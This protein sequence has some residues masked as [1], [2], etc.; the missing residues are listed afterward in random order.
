MALDL[1][2]RRIGVAVSD[3]AGIMAHPLTTL[4]T[5]KQ[6]GFPL[7]ALRRL[8]VDRQVGGVVVGLPRRLDGSR[9]P[10]AQAAEEVA[11]ELHAALE[12]PVR[13]WDE[14]LTTVEAQRLLREAGAGRKKRRLATDRVAAALILQGFL[15]HEGDTAAGEGE[16][17]GGQGSKNAQEP[18]EAR[19]T[20]SAP[21]R[22][23]SAQQGTTKGTRGA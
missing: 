11:A 4:E 13:L 2:A 9:G 12:L 16:A 22:S 20:T 7:E 3:D 6:G 18:T 10:E 19:Q 8:L 15:D 5:G 17:S 1:G 21:E 14:R 23:G